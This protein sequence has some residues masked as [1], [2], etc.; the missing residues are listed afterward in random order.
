MPLRLS[1]SISRHG[2]TSVQNERPLRADE[3]GEGVS[4]EWPPMPARSSRRELEI[5]SAIAEA[6]NSAPTVQEALER[7][8]HGLTGL[9]R[10]DRCDVLGHIIG[11]AD[12]GPKT[13]VSRYRL[14]LNSQAVCAK[15]FGNHVQV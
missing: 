13:Q 6:L 15:E 11:D 8:V 9:L 12:E 10:C 7:V 5:V 14:Y 2:W 3:L 1:Q 4:L